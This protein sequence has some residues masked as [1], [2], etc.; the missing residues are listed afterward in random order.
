MA[1]DEHGREGGKVARSAFVAL[2]LSAAHGLGCGHDAVVPV[3]ARPTPSASPPLTAEPVLGKSGVFPSKRFGLELPLEDG[4][5]WQIDDHRTPWLS[6]K[7]PST[8][9]TLML[10]LWRD[11]NRM[12]RDKC[13]AR[14]RSWRTLPRKEDS[15]ILEEKA[16]DV[17]PGFDT[18]AVVGLVPDERSGEL[19]GFVMAFGGFS[20]KC[21]SYIYATTAKG[22]GAELTVA[23]RL[24]RIVEGS[25]AKIKIESDLAP[26]LDRSPEP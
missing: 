19:F 11:E 25:L 20:H 4:T 8:S 21:F 15:N 13:E 18:T 7:Q 22:P 5:T 6:A 2:A 23:D 24:A 16:V 9:S 17:P 26:E 3:T 14:A 10:R 1:R 12:N